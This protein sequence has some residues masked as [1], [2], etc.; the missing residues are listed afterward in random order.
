MILTF[1]NTKSF[2]QRKFDLLFGDWGLEVLP[3]PG[4]E[5][6]L[7]DQVQDALNDIRMTP[8]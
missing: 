5:H 1:P 3:V 2:M 4:T 8:P 6:F 7:G